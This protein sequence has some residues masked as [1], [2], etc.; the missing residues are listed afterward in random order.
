MLVW[1]TLLIVAL[2]GYIFIVMIY[3][4]LEN[5]ETSTTFS[6]LLVFIFL[7]FVGIVLYFLFGRRLRKKIKKTYIRQDLVNRLSD[8]H[9][10]LIEQQKQTIEILQNK[11]FSS[12]NRK[13]IRLLYR[14]SDSV[15]TRLNSVRIFFMGKEKFDVLIDDL[16]KAQKY[17]H[18]EYFIWKPDKLTVRVV[19]VLKKKKLQKG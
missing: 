16:K 2:Y 7:P 3:L 15:L 4:L 12:G 5:R 17:I 9:D 6:W 8:T 13:L 11:Y 10:Q 19:D 18:M 14:N 1:D